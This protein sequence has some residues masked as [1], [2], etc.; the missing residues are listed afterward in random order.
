MNHQDLLDK[1]TYNVIQGNLN[2]KYPGHN[3]RMK[4]QPGVIEL[5]QKALNQNID[6]KEIIVESLA[7]PMDEV[8]EKYVTD[9]L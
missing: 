1:I 5:I 3:L 7:K 9:T 2:V 8:I 6:P 4:G